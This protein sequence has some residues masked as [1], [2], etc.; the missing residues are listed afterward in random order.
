M[1]LRGWLRFRVGDEE[2]QLGEG[3]TSE[4]PS[5]MRHRAEARPDG[6]T[7]IDIFSPPRAEW[8]QAEE[9]EPGAGRWP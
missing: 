5:N 9:G 1:V 8:E 4:I 3:E 7:V 2:R 6:A